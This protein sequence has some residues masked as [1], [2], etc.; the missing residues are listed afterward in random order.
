MFVIGKPTM[1][2]EARKNWVGNIARVSAVRERLLYHS[3]S[4]GWGFILTWAHRITGVAVVAFMFF[5]IFTLSG[6]YAPAKFAAK[7]EFLR[8]GIFAFMEWILAVPV[9]FHA[10]NG[11]RLILYELF[12]VRDD[13]Q[14]IRWVL[15]LG[16]VYVLSLGFF[17]IKNDQQVSAGFFWFVVVLVSLIAAFVVA[18]KLW[19]TKNDWMWKLQ[20]ISGAFLLPMV[21]GHF[22]FMHLTYQAGHDI[23]TILARLSHVGIKLMD[24]AFVLLVF[25][26]AGFG[27]SAI[28]GDYMENGYWR[29]ALRLAVVIVMSVFGYAG[30][31]LVI[32]L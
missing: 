4:R 8:H 13:R 9:I 19:P 12:R 6:L 22:F 5:H 21:S 25:F 10:F 24:S 1:N 32:S 23:N 3:S 20:R 18:R 28:I 31:K 15:G 14:M 7:M 29:T 17:M 11:A 26:H 27:I 30:A 2:R 16:A